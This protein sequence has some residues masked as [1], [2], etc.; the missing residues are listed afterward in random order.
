V[1]AEPKS[2]AV[3]ASVG[4]PQ[5]DFSTW[6]SQIFWL[7]LTFGLL[8][9]VLARF[10]LPVIGR[11]LSD[12]SDRIADD[13]NAATA[14]QREAE[15]AEASYEKALKDARAKAHNVAETT[16]A[17]VDAE[18]AAEIAEADK[19]AERASAVAEDRI[20]DIRTA[21]LKNIDTVA[22]D[23]AADVFSKL[24]GKVAKG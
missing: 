9:V 24:S 1:A 5:L 23:V 22:K 6:S 21:A 15:E 8:Y 7:F 17:S 12:R 2:D 16:R 19:E 14:M 3:E 20:R 4:L 11:T 10:I 13:L 18:M